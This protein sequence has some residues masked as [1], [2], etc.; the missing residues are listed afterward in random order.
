MIL[1]MRRPFLATRLPGACILMAGLLLGAM[2]SVPRTCSAAAGPAEQ[3]IEA[4]VRV[5]RALDARREA[6]A[7]TAD[8]AAQR[9]LAG[10]KLHL[11]GETGIMA[12]LMGRAGGLCGAQMLALEKGQLPAGPNDI[13]LLSDYGTPGKLKTALEKL[14][15]TKALVIVFASAENPLLRQPPGASVGQVANLPEAPQIGNLPHGGPY[16]RAIPFGAIPLE[17]RL[18]ALGSGE[19]LIPAASPAIA[20]AEWTFVAELLGACRRQ[21]KQLAVIYSWAIRRT[22]MRGPRRS[23]PWVRERSSSLLPPLPPHR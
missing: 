2:T 20:T 3:Y 18:L 11:A 15:A 19:R 13:V 16:L 6:L 17:S 10:G 9:L 23:M 1:K 5:V 4:Q 12:E 8:E 7:D 22:K 21:H 14:A